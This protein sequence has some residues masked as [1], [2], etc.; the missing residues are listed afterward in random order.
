MTTTTSTPTVLLSIDSTNG[1]VR[2]NVKLVRKG[3]RYG[4]NVVHTGDDPLV[5]FY[6]STHANRNGFGSLGQFAA[7]YC[8]ENLLDSYGTDTGL[9]LDGGVLE[10]MVPAKGVAEVH[11]ALLVALTQEYN[12][13]LIR[14]RIEKSWPKGDQRGFIVINKGENGWLINPVPGACWFRT[15]EQA[16]FGIDCLIG[17]NGVGDKFWS[18]FGEG[19]VAVQPVVQI[20]PK[21]TNVGCKLR[22]EAGKVISL[23]T[24][25]LID[26]PNLT[27]TYGTLTV[28]RLRD[29]PTSGFMAKVIGIGPNR[30]KNLNTKDLEEAIASALEWIGVD[31]RTEDDSSH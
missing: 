18:L 31:G 26:H 13:Y 8:A 5:E 28:Y 17:A 29:Y 3:E 9:C 15:V 30:E 11:A 1:Q 24:S 4:E 14:P 23:S 19:K 12:G 27:Q 16:K 7:R 2:F 21:V 6:D 10:W 25:L 20:K 22:V